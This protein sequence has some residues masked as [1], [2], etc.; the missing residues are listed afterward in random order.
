[1][2]RGIGAFWAAVPAT[3][4]IYHKSD[5]LLVSA[6]FNDLAAFIITAMGAD[7]MRT[8]HITTIRALARCR[9]RQG[10]VRTPH[11]TF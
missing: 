3:Q 4:Q 9:I 1:M 11:L 2:Q 7:M 10:I 6:L 5:R 8:H